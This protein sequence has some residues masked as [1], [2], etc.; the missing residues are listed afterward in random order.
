MGAQDALD[1]ASAEFV[2]NGVLFGGG[3]GDEELV[4]DVDV[5]LGVGYSVDVGVCDRVFGFVAGGPFACA[6]GVSLLPLSSKRVGWRGGYL[7]VSW[8]FGRLDARG[9]SLPPSSSSPK[10]MSLFIPLLKR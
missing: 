10:R 2:A 5:M 3:G 4:F 8:I 1:D 7:L 9:D 6:V